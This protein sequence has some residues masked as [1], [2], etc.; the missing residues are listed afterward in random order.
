MLSEY[1]SSLYSEYKTADVNTL[2]DFD[3][4]ADGTRPPMH[5]WVETQT[6]FPPQRSGHAFG[7][8]ERCIVHPPPK[9]S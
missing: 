9:R 8:A 6:A 7:T 4:K 2:C 5:F 1:I 3:V